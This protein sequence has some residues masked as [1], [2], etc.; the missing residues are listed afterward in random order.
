MR[1]GFLPERGHATLAVLGLVAIVAAFSAGCAILAVPQ[2]TQPSQRVGLAW[3]DD[4]IR[5][6]LRFFNGSESEDRRT[7]SV[8]YA[9]TAA[10]VAA[11]MRQFGLQPAVHGDFR[12]VYQTP[13][14]L[15]VDA[16]LVALGNDT[17]FFY[18]GVDFLAD[19]RSDSGL[20]AF[21]RVD[22]LA[23]DLANVR[24]SHSGIAMLDTRTTDENHLS[25]LRSRGFRV[26]LLV[27]PLL[28]TT[29]ARP[30]AGLL[31]MQISSTAASELLGGLSVDDVLQRGVDQSI[32]MPH[33]VRLRIATDFREDAGAINVMGYLAG[34]HPELREELVIVCADLDAIGSVGGVRTLDLQNF[35][36]HASALLELAR[37]YETLDRFGFAP[38]RTL[39]FA[40]FSGARL[41]NAGL[42]AY[43]QNP[44]WEIDHTVAVVYLG[45]PEDREPEVSNLLGAHD[46][47]LFSVAPSA[48]PLHEGGMVI[49][50]S[51]ADVRRAGDRAESINIT[52]IS[53]SDVLDEAVARAQQRAADAHAVVFPLTTGFSHEIIQ[54]IVDSETE[55]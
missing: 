19:A 33:D 52:S 6:H 11:R 25:T 13:L 47:P 26:A 5:E 43:L 8:G 31:V 17:L 34:K 40:V 51:P 12:L 4:F 3:R 7:G 54:S 21:D 24:T 35:G 53:L 50:P 39:L 10:Y 28:P 9:R 23:G 14:N 18:P 49:D 42:K 48:V 44:L 46:I 45:L 15:P 36:I 22:V 20:V 29:A 2:E 41:S 55:Q 30:I 16:D 38:E 27:G 1:F 37:N 32:Q